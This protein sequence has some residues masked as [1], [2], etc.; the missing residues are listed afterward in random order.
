[1]RIYSSM[2]DLI[3]HTP[4]V[5]LQRFEERYALQGR[6]L[7]KV[8]SFNPG[9]S[10]KDRAAL[11]MI[12]DGF[13]MNLINQD[14][15][16][17]EPTSGNTGIGLALACSFYKLR[18][19]LT[20]PESMSSERRAILKAYGAELV[21]TPAAEGMTGAIAK[22]KEIARQHENSFI[23]G[24]F[25]NEAN[26]RAHALTTGPEIWADTDGRV[27]A[28]VS[29]VG[30]GGTITGVGS[31]LKGRS[32]KIKMIAVEPAASAVLSGRPAGPHK[33]QGI[34]AGF[35]PRVL[36]R[37]LIDEIIQVTDEDALALGAEACRTE[38]LFCG[39]SAGAALKAGIEICQRPEYKDKMVVVIIPDSG[40]RYLSTPMFS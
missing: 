21:L 14:T 28:V 5:E 29:A 23:P 25:E 2:L 37:E 1:M 13:L 32:S 4:L 8:E 10:I 17:V 11:S 6:L 35:V 22:A 36:Q 3:G 31:F 15:V 12:K 19:I 39:I 33:I 20:L 7:A 9:G 30:S 34:G 16:I 40:D 24:Q 18:L 26:P 38:G 27:A